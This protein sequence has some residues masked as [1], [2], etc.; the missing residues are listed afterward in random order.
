[1]GEQLEFITF[2]L[3]LF[4]YAGLTAVTVMAAGGHVPTRLLRMTAAVIVVHVLMVWHVRY[5][6]QFSEATRNGYA[7]FALFHGALAAILSSLVTSP[8]VARRLLT[9][10]FLVVS[11]GAIAATFKYDVVRH[12]RVP[13]LLIAVTGIIM[14]GYRSRRTERRRTA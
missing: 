6:W 12:Y 13:V 3:A 11:L 2:L 8:P 9:A 5:D 1:L 14:S 4:G 7:G 10:A